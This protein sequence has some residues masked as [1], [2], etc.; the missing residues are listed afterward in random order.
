MT[1]EVRSQKVIGLPPNAPS[2]GRLSLEPSQHAV[3]KPRPW[4]KAHRTDSETW[5]STLGEISASDIV[6]NTEPS[7]SWEVGGSSD[8]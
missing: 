3:R 2:L 6:L 5:S 1:P 7:T 8:L 4:G